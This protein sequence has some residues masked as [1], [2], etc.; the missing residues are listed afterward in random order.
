MKLQFSITILLSFSTAGWY[1]VTE[2]N[3]LSAVFVDAVSEIPA[4]S[5]PSCCNVTIEASGANQIT[6]NAID[7]PS[8][9]FR[10]STSCFR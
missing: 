4:S 9:T 10:C 1:V 2:G 6:R 5:L 3:S 7:L 8:I